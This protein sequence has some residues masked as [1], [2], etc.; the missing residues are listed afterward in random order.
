MRFDFVGVFVSKVFTQIK[1][2]ELE[3]DKI[4]NG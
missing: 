1:R 4:T 3:R 2:N